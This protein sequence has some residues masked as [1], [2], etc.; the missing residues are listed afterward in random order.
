MGQAGAAGVSGWL[1]TV[2]GY[3]PGAAG[4]QTQEVL[5][6]IFAIATLVPA[7]GF[8]LLS[9]VLWLWYPLHKRR[10]EENTAQLKLRR[11]G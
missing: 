1:L 3:V 10:V 4:G 11:K 8:V 7:L 9:A 5:H 6:G 2:I